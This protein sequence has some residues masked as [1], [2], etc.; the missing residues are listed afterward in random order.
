MPRILQLRP[1]LSKAASEQTAAR[2]IVARQ[3]ECRWLGELARL[4]GAPAT[5]L[6][7]GGQVRTFSD[8]H[9]AAEFLRVLD[10]GRDCFIVAWASWGSR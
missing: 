10:A 8:P 2:H 7:S 3:R 1:R 6:A 4:P 5:L 9:S